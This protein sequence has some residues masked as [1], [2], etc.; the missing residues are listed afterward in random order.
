MLTFYL[1]PTVELFL[2]IPGL[3][4]REVISTPFNF[5]L[6]TYNCFILRHEYLANSHHNLKALKLNYQQQK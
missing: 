5:N 4:F 2:L 6:K 1:K 3:Y